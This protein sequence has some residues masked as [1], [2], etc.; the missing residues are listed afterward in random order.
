MNL[1]GTIRLNPLGFCILVGAFLILLLYMTSGSSSASDM[2]KQES[3]TSTVNLKSLLIAAV[4][5]AEKGGSEV[6]A[7]RLDANLQ[8]KSKGET[9]EGVDDPVTNADFRSHCIMYHSL[10]ENFPKIK[11]N[12]FNSKD[13]RI[14]RIDQIITLQIWHVFVSYSYCI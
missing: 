4:E 3:S 11:V 2:K 1:G 10:V 12:I 13:L 14:V 6:K 8:V 9:K 7:T 5:V